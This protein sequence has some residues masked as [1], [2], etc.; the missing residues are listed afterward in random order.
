MKEYIGD[1]KS[2]LIN[3]MDTA[4]P[5]MSGV[6]QNQDS[7]MKG[8]IAQRWYYERIEPA[9]EDAF[10]EFY[11]KT[12]RKYGFVEAYRCEDAEYILVGMGCYMETAKAAVNY[13]RNKGIA[14]GALTVFVFRPFPARVIVEALKDCKAFTVFERMDDPLSTAG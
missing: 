9:M 1:P 4:N 13:L 6:V 12:G 7:Y 8:K 14:A 5:L 2:K 3:L 10:A 11:R